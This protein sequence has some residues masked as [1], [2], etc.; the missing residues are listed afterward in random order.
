[1]G[2]EDG[3]STLE[4]CQIHALAAYIIVSACQAK[5]QAHSGSE[6]LEVIFDGGDCLRT[7]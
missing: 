2:P 4:F 7:A 3:V 5:Q 6:P 1:M